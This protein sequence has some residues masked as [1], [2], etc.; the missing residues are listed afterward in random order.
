MAGGSLPTEGSRRRRVSPVPMLVV[1][2]VVAVLLIAGGIWFALGGA[3]GSGDDKDGSVE[4]PAEGTGEEYAELEEELRTV[5]DKNPDDIDARRSLAAVLAAQGKYDEAIREYTQITSEDPSDDEAFYQLAILERQTG[6]TED[7]LKHLQAAVDISPEATYLDDLARTSMQVGRY[8]DAI[9]AWKRLLE[10]DGLEPQRRAEILSAL[11][12]AYQD[13]KMYEE[14][15]AAL[16]EAVALMPED[17][18]LKARLEAM[19]N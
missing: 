11:A 15:K 17:E 12:S 6:L 13:A 19:G 7:A 8:E 18:E 2:A 16:Q 9:A 1:G 14:A 3:V 4:V 10:D 5:L